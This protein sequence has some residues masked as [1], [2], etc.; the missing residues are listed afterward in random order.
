MPIVSILIFLNHYDYAQN[1]DLSPQRF[2]TSG[3]HVSYF[4]SLSYANN[5]FFLLFLLSFCIMQENFKLNWKRIHRTGGLQRSSKLANMSRRK[6]KV[7][8]MQKVSFQLTVT[9]LLLGK[10]YYLSLAQFKFSKN[11][12]KSPRW[13]D[14]Y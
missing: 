1:I 8:E 5:S 9:L 2:L 12:A 3:G 6:F 10:P 13:L 4:L 7:F 14:V 11:L